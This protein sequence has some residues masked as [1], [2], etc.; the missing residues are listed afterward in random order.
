MAAP[1][2]RLSLSAIVLV[3][4]GCWGVDGTGTR[5]LFACF[6]FCMAGTAARLWETGA[7]GDGRT[8]KDGHTP[9]QRH[10]LQSTLESAIWRLQGINAQRPP[11]LPACRYSRMLV[12]RCGALFTKLIDCARCTCTSIDFSTAAPRTCAHTSQF[13]IGAV[14]AISRC[15]C[16]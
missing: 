13:T 12:A 11:E 1:T 8:G 2:V 3:V 9:Q 5:C 6:S 7:M 16:V 14:V 10:A 4:M 15:S